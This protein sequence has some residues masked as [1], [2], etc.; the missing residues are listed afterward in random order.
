PRGGGVRAAG[1]LGRHR[2]RLRPVAAP[3]PGTR[4]SR[5]RAIARRTSTITVM[6]GSAPRGAARK[7]AA[8]DDG[9]AKAGRMSTARRELV[10][11]E[12]Y[13][14]ATRLFA[15][16]GFAGTS[17]QDIADALGI[18]RPALYYYVKSKDELLAKLVTEVTNGPLAGSGRS[19]PAS[20]PWVCSACATGW[21]GGSTL[22]AATPPSRS[23]SSS[24]TWP[25]APCSA[26]TT[27][28]STAR[29]PPRP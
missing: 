13:E 7:K 16:R 10:E 11:N 26:P 25:S 12:L 4:A 19:T 5:C 27:T 22:A 21:P 15:E 20:P 23:S 9:E 6:S 29:G 2:R 17:L 8:G 3:G 24:P 28:S 14:H 1:A 18:T